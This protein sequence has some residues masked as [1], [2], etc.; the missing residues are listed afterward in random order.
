V[1]LGRFPVLSHLCA[2]RLSILYTAGGLNAVRGELHRLRNQG[3]I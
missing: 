2:Q 3:I 1:G